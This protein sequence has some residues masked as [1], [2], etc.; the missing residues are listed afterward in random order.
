[1]SD[2][3]GQQ[4]ADYER[5]L[6]H[7]VFLADLAKHNISLFDKAILT[8]SSSALGLSL[9]FTDKLGGLAAVKNPAVL[10]GCLGALCSGNSSK[11]LVL[12][13]RLAGRCASD[14]GNR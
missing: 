1:M 8:L 11:P 12:Q 3:D 10:G 6:A 7:R 2:E 4:N 14:Q 5:L 9:L 13:G